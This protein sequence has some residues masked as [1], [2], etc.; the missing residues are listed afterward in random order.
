MKKVLFFLSL[1][2]CLNI[3]AQSE[4]S[5]NCKATINLIKNDLLE[6]N[7]IVSDKIKSKY[8]INTINGCDYLSILTKVGSGYDRLALESEGILVGSQVKNIVSIKYPVNKIDAIFEMP[9]VEYLQVAEKMAPN[10]NK[11]L[12]DTKADSVHKG[13]GL[14]SSFTGKDVLIG[15]TDWGFDYSHPMFYDTLLENTRILAA[16]DQFKTSGPTPDDYAYGTEYN[17]PAELLDAAADTANIYSFATHGSHVAGIAGGSGAGTIYR[18]VAFESQFLFTTFLVDESA[19]LDAWEWMYNISQ[20]EGK[21]LVI[22]MS[23]GLYNMGAL[24][25]TS[26][27]S[28][29]LDAYS[30]MGVVFVTSGGNNG[31]VDFHIK[32]EFAGDTLLSRV[33][34]YDGPV[35][36]LWG[37]SVHAWGEADES[38]IGG[39][40]VL[41]GS[42]VLMTE[43][44]WYNT[45]TTDTYIDTFLIVP[46]TTDTIFYNLSMD[47]A[48]P[49]ND[50]PQMRLRVKKGSPYYKIVLKAAAETGT[51]HFWNVTE[52]T[53]DVGNW[54][55]PF[56][57]LG[58]GYTAG[59]N[60][61]GIGTPAC[62]ETA[63]SVAAFSA[64]YETG[65]GTV[66]G[67]GPAAFS[68]IG[69]MMNDN[70][71]PDISAPGV[72][73]G[74]SIS[75][76]TD[77]SYTEIL[78]VSF[79]GR[80][81]PFA[82][83]SGTSMASP[84]VA[85]IVALM[86]EANPYLSPWQVKLIII[87]TAREDFYTGEI[88][89]TGSTKWGWG[90]I[91]AYAAV[92]RAL[93]TTGWE[94]VEKPL[95]WTIYPNP[96]NGEIQIK[97]LTGNVQSIQIIDLSG[98]LYGE[99][100]SVDD[101][102]TEQLGSGTYILRIVKDDHVEQQRFIKQ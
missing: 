43:S 95:S 62:S 1:L 84:A 87:E 24:D 49:T 9:G 2:F 91:N 21:R 77:G 26:V 23:W 34:F 68:S 59:D 93:N 50:R 70:L 90:K 8:P 66:I 7:S 85:G 56:Q 96:T 13:L 31:D 98:K 25:G 40:R 57:S 54:G 5:N 74:S 19:V 81:Y 55:M 12:Y 100:Q 65:T 69:P 86:L 15:V 46:E 83:L 63:I 94:T 71:K 75:S 18:G 38:F 28:E 22:N 99:F 44:P 4:A 88:P 41:N 60:L 27:L 72:S 101:L 79:E 30:D 89:D 67:G 45:L 33:Q 64:S 32:K 14:P 6:N 61:Y 16:W 39:I 76:Y 78:S 102:S 53:T 48:Y 80:D 10:L 73:V 58:A 36:N 20:D 29:A 97:N 35:V 17:T 3:F 47:A 51:V 52:L 92:K 82:K 11:V 42:N 37:Q